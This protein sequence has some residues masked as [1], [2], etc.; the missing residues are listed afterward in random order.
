MLFILISFFLPC[1]QTNPNMHKNKTS[2]NISFM[3]KMNCAPP[4]DQFK[5]SNVACTL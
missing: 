2:A 5:Y 4:E 1:T 3:M